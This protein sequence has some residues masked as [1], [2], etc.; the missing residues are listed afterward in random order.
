MK[1]RI[2]AGVVALA[3]AGIVML[4]PR[5]WY[6]EPPPAWKKQVRTKGQF[7]PIPEA[8]ISTPEGRIAHDLVLPDAAPKP[9]P[10]D[11]EKAFGP[12]YHRSN[13]SK[14]AIL[15]FNHLCDTEAGEWIFEKVKGVEGVYFARPELRVTETFLSQVYGPEAPAVETEMH[16]SPED[17]ESH[18][19]WFVDPPWQNF[20]FFEE[21]WWGAD[22]QQD[23]NKPYVRIS[24]YTSL[25]V[26]DP[27][28]K[29]I[30]Y[31]KVTPN[32]AIGIDSI[33]TEYAYTWRGIVRPRDREFQ[34]GGSEVIIYHRISKKVVA[35]KRMFSLTRSNVKRGITAQWH[36]ANGCA[37]HRRTEQMFFVDFPQEVLVGNPEK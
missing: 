34:I 26:K 17:L 36:F 8:W 12:W 32:Q 23:I 35:V 29:Q 16:W 37:G 31:E 22:W 5:T 19:R 25:A 10:F 15:Y 2:V 28:S 14:V 6:V 3:V 33:S 24:G 30:S 18:G 13:K 1:M 7:Y 11:F 20:K 21:P 4:K 27:Y 9:V